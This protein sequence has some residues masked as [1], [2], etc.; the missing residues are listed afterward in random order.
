[1]KLSSTRLS[2]QL[3]LMLRG[4]HHQVVTLVAAF[5]EAHASLWI[6]DEVVFALLQLEGIDVELGINISC[7]EQKLMSRDA[8]QGLGVFT[9]ALNVEV[10]QILRGDDDRRILFTHTLR[11]VSDVFHGGEIGEEQVELI[12]AGGSVAIGQK[13]V[14]HVG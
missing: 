5:V 11:K 13:L 2:E 3:C 14:A 10:L 6:A 9:D 7:I 12:N 8:E 4:I 1:M